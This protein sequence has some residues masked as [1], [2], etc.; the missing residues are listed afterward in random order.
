MKPLPTSV[1]VLSDTHSHIDD[2]I[3]KYTATA[4]E[5][6]HAGDLGH[7]KVLEVLRS[8]CKVLRVVMGNIDSVSDYPHL[9]QEEV[10]LCG[11][12]KI[13]MIHIGGYPGRYAKSV[14]Q[15]IAS[16]RPDIFISGHSHILKVMPDRK[17]DLLHINPGAAGRHG[18]HIERTMISF[19]IEQ[20]KIQNLNVI[21]L[22]K[23]SSYP[24]V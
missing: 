24:L 3:L 10:F 23:R 17:N 16:H 8:S 6:W 11:G 4:D 12:L 15:K 18:F 19:E 9:P 7:P 14:G 22:G 20:G 5:V 21:K 13:F 2:T 1:L